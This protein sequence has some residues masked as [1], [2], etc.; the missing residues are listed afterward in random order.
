MAVLL[1]V[2]YG[3]G[4]ADGAGRLGG[5][6]GVPHVPCGVDL[7][8]AHTP[9]DATVLTLRD[10]RPVTFLAR[11]D[12]SKLPRDTSAWDRYGRRIEATHALTCIDSAAT[13]PWARRFGWR[14]VAS[15]EAADLYAI[16]P[17]TTD[18]ASGA[19]R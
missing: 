5:G 7:V 1:G 8:V 6:A 13:R 15:N 12:A 11:R 18:T 17:P 3:R 2:H 9:P 16:E 4:V 14:R 19:G 10:P